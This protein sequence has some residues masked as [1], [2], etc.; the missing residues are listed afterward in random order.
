M[1]RAA[2]AQVCGLATRK[3]RFRAGYD[4]DLLLVDGNPLSDIGALTHPVA[5]MV[6]GQWVDVAL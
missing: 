2:S 5:V 6:R 1:L 3:G 4:A